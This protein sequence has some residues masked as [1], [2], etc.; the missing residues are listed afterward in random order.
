[1]RYWYIFVV[2]YSLQ[3]AFYDVNVKY[4]NWTFEHFPHELL[5]CAYRFPNCLEKGQ[6]LL[7]ECGS[8]SDAW[9]HARKIQKYIIT[10]PRVQL[11]GVDKR[12]DVF[13]SSVLLQRNSQVFSW[14]L[15]Q[16]G[17]AHDTTDSV[18]KRCTSQ[19]VNG[20]NYAQLAFQ[21]PHKECSQFVWSSSFQ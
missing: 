3:C 16:L 18:W 20:V 9:Y 12:I 15:W 5:H 19:F 10:Y 17:V 1:M 8:T 4:R 21:V 11:T 6:V 14:S 13:P 2:Y 7:S